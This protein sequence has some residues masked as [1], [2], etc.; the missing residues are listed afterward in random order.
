LEDSPS[1]ESLSATAE[2]NN[3]TL[4]QERLQP[5]PYIPLPEDF[6]TYLDSLDGRYRREL[7]RKIRNAQRYFIPVQIERVE[8]QDDLAAAMEDFFIMMREESEKA[9]FLT[10]AMESQMQAIVRTA[11]EHGWL[12][13][14]FL[15]VGRERAAGYLNFVYG[16]RVWVYNSARAEKFSSLSP[17]IAQIGLLI[18]QA[19]EDGMSAFDLMRGDEEYKYHLGGQDRWVVKATITR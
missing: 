9:T 3:L 11:A 8:N 5:A 18:Q 14:S 6:D 13:L 7:V 1:L 2:K 16:K 4:I 19:I 12:D 10:G 17:G 15:S